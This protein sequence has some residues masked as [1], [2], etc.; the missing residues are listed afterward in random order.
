MYNI[1]YFIILLIF[2]ELHF[3]KSYEREKVTNIL[4]TLLETYIIFVSFYYL[5]FLAT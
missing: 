5:I 3:I 4:I 2:V 1:Y